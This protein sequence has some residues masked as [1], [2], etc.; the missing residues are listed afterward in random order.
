MPNRSF[1]FHLHLQFLLLDKQL[2]YLNCASAAT[3]AAKILWQR[4]RVR[5]QRQ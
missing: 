5:E 2:N 1:Q 4:Q 3:T